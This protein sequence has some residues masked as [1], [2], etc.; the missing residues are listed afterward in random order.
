M[1]S[2][3]RL[4]RFNKTELKTIRDAVIEATTRDE[5]LTTI[6]E[7]IA[8]KEKLETEGPN[9]CIP[10]SFF[11]IDPDYRQLLHDNGI[12]NLAQ[13]RSIKEEDLWSLKGMTHG[14]F[15][16]ISWAR[17]FFNMEP[18]V[19]ETK[20]KTNTKETKKNK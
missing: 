9:A 18:L 20:P 6:E 11:N 8:Q 3:G 16:Q 12:E 19:Q 13:L 15:E 7:I 14:G 2:F 5:L 10:V 4:S 17:E 1:A